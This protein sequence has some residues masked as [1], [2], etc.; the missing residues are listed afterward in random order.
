MLVCLSMMRVL[1]IKDVKK[2]RNEEKTTTTTIK[3]STQISILYSSST[4]VSVQKFMLKDL[5]RFKN[6]L[7]KKRDF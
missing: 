5:N 3:N 6:R 4:F 1:K 7:R 2:I